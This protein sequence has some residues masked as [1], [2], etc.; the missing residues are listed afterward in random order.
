MPVGLYIIPEDDARY[1][2]YEEA[3]I[4]G[5]YEIKDGKI[6][7]GR[8]IFDYDKKRLV[9]VDPN[10]FKDVSSMKMGEIKNLFKKYGFD[11]DIGYVTRDSKGNRTKLISILGGKVRR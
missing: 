9:K 2:N 7:I 8:V 11:V 4:I 6:I 1:L 10:D 5:E 3:Y